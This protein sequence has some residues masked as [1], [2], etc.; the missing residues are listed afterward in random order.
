MC[1]Q[2][3]A[4]AENTLMTNKNFVFLVG[5][6][7][8]VVPGGRMFYCWCFVSPRDL[9][10]PSADRRETSPR[11]RKVL[12]HDNLVPKILGALL[13]KSWG[14]KRA[15][16][17]STSDNFELRSWIS[18][19]RM[20][21]SSIANLC[22]RQRFQLPALAENTSMRKEI[23]VPPVAGWCFV[24]TLFQSPGRINLFASLWLKRSEPQADGRTICRHLANIVLLSS[25]FI[26][27]YAYIQSWLMLCKLFCALCDALDD[28][29]LRYLLCKDGWLQSAMY[30]VRYFLYAL[31]VQVRYG[32]RPASARQDRLTNRAA[33]SRLEQFFLNRVVKLLNMYVAWRSGI[34]WQ[35]R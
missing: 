21:I 7:G 6:P 31:N 28:Y 13:Q 16:F 15:K 9:R 23:P 19:E 22:D 11:D 2:L 8:A 5:P 3:P 10:A 4:L 30:G 12:L 29:F 14:Q 24:W 35:C 25:C 17:G 20:E 18:L 34:S 27:C 26:Q 1:S 33:H 32:F